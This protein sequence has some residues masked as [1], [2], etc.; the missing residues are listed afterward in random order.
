M[1]LVELEAI[2]NNPAFS[3]QEIFRPDRS[4]EQWAEIIPQIGTQGILAILHKHFEDDPM[5]LYYT[6]QLNYAVNIGATMM[7]SDDG[8]SMPIIPSES[9]EQYFQRRVELSQKLEQKDSRNW[10]RKS[11]T[12]YY[13]NIIDQ[14]QT[15]NYESA[16]GHIELQKDRVLGQLTIVA[17]KILT[18]TADPITGYR[19]NE[20]Q[21]AT[22]VL[23]YSQVYSFLDKIA[24]NI[25]QT[26]AQV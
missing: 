14:C 10:H 25:P 4:Q 2:L 22:Q 20:L 7:E 19:N 12:I 23:T 16:R 15:G 17:P 3:F 13:Q 8:D 6:S 11:L 21:I 26:R 9:I 1:A 18:A 24:Q 5:Q